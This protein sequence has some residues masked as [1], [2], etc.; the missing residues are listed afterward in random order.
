MRKLFAGIT[1][2][3]VMM[4]SL[5]FGAVAVGYDVVQDIDN[6]SVQNPTPYEYVITEVNGD[7]INGLAITNITDSNAGIVLSQSIDGVDLEVGDIIQVT[8]GEAFDDIVEIAYK[9]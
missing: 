2:M 4:I 3:S 5:M 8:Y 6:D 1:M 9:N 7:E